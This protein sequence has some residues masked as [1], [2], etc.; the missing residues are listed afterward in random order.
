[1]P[2]KLP[3]TAIVS[4]LRFDLDDNLLPTGLI[5][6]QQSQALLHPFL[7]RAYINEPR[8]VRNKQPLL[9]QLR[10]NLRQKIFS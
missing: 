5:A 7:Q 3:T 9:K 1:M 4:V 6:P 8:L 2:L 10:E